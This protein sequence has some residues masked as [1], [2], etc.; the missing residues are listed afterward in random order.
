MEIITTIIIIIAIII[1]PIVHV[2]GFHGFQVTVVTKNVD[3][4]CD[5]TISVWMRIR[6]PCLPHSFV[7][8]VFE[9]K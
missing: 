9:V 3:L 2:L 7:R 1:I 5:I 4:L 6:F 8:L